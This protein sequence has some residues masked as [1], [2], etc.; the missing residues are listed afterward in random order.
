MYR[1]HLC[2]CA[3]TSVQGDGFRDRHITI[4][5]YSHHHPPCCT[6]EPPRTH[7]SPEKRHN[8]NPKWWGPPSSC[9]SAVKIL[10]RE[11]GV[12]PPPAHGTAYHPLSKSFRWVYT[13]NTHPSTIHPFLNMRNSTELQSDCALTYTGHN[14]YLTTSFCQYLL[15]AH[16]LAIPYPDAPTGLSPLITPRNLMDRQTQ[17]K[18]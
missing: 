13:P 14:L 1:L 4:Y 3:R 15:Q 5:P 10:T 7:R 2:H 16:I 11:K 12:G 8:V 18:V 9:W 6:T 17:S